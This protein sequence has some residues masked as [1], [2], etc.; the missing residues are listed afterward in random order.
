MRYFKFRWPESE[1]SEQGDWGAS[2]WYYEFGPDGSSVRQVML[3]DNGYRL[4][5]GPEHLRD[6]YGELLWDVRLGEFDL[7][8]GEEISQAEF[9]QVW[10]SGPW[11]NDPTSPSSSDS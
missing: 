11:T 10:Q 1:S 9:E 2:W 4:R 5:Y 6:G 3:Y 7:S 8:Q